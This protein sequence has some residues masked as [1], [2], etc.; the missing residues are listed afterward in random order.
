MAEGILTAL[1]AALSGLGG[2]IEGVQQYR[3]AE[4]K[5]KREEAEAA[6]QQRMDDAT[7]RAE[8]LRAT[9]AQGK[10]VP[11][12]VFASYTMPGATPLQP[13]LTQKIGGKDFMFSPDI[14]KAEAHRESVMKER[15]ARAK[16]KEEQTVLGS[17]LESMDVDGKKL[18]TPEQAKKY[19]ALPSNERSS[20]VAAAIRAA[21]PQ[22]TGKE[23]PS[24]TEKRLRGAQFLATNTKNPALMNALNAT[25]AR[26]PMS[27]YDPEL[28]AYDIMKSRV[29]PT[30]VTANKG[31]TAPKKKDSDGLS[32][33]A[34]MAE[35]RRRQAAGGKGEPP[36]V[37]AA[38]APV[39][40]RQETLADA[41]DKEARRY[42]RWEQIKAKN[43]NMKDDDITAQVKREIP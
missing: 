17:A 25:F 41:A 35:A 43:P 36:K 2:G 23:E 20:I 14:E 32:D 19:S 8:E 21:T 13:A 3:E 28:A 16:K 15:L 26:D 9:G 31:Y 37:T 24:D 39:A 4:R 18:F 6:R 30:G 38:A 42:E 1:Q 27:L 29:V 12:D 22:R 7:I 34:I 10:L 33:D 5:R 11:S 40:A